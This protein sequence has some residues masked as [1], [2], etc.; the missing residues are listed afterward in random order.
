MINLERQVKLQFDAFHLSSSSFVYHSKAA[1]CLKQMSD[2]NSTKW[3]LTKHLLHKHFM[4]ENVKKGSLQIQ[5][6]IVL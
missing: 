4:R 2:D 5:T 6:V 3:R 1:T